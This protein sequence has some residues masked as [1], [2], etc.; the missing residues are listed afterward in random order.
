MNDVGIKNYSMFIDEDGLA[1]GYFESEDPEN[2]LE[3]FA[4]PEYNL[5]MKPPVM[6]NDAGEY[7]VPIPGVTKVI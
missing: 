1:V 7:Y 6:P 3:Q 5:D 2:S 4:Q